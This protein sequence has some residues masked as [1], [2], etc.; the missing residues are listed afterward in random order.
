MKLY[1]VEIVACVGKQ[2]SSSEDG[3]IMFLQMLVGLP[4]YLHGVTEDHRRK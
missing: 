2:N 3:D 4:N 1:L